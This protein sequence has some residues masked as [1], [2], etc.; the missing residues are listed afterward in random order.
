MIAKT[1]GQGKKRIYSDTFKLYR[2]TK[3]RSEL[4]GQIRQG[5]SGG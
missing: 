3:K 4:R 5:D 2:A 1:K